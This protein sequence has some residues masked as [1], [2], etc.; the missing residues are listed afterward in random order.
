MEN[1]NN[2]IAKSTAIPKR[3]GIRAFFRIA[4]RTTL[5]VLSLGF[6]LILLIHIPPVQNQV[7][8]WFFAGLSS[9][10]RKEISCESFRFSITGSIELHNLVIHHHPRFGEEKM[11]EIKKLYLVFD[12]L[13]VGRQRIIIRELF[14]DTPQIRVVVAPDRNHNFQKDPFKKKLKQ[15]K[16]A[17]DDDSIVQAVFR[18]IRC[19]HILIKNAAFVI[20]HQPSG[21]QLDVPSVQLEGHYRAETDRIRIKAFGACIGNS[22]P[23]RL[24][25][26]ADFRLEADVFGGGVDKS[27]LTVHSSNGKVWFYSHCTLKNFRHPSLSFSGSLRSELDEIKH[28]ARVN[29]ELS[30]LADLRFSGNGFADDLTVN[31]EFRGENIQFGQFRFANFSGPVTYHNQIITV[32]EASGSAYDGSI[33]G[34]G[35]ITIQKENKS[36][37]FVATARE[38]DLAELTRDLKIP[39]ELSTAL[40]VDLKIDAD[41]FNPEDVLVTGSA[42]GIEKFSAGNSV[43]PDDE[44]TPLLLTGEFLFKNSVFEIT[45]A[46]ITHPDHEITMDNCRFAKSVLAGRIDGSTSDLQDLA[47]RIDDAVPLDYQFPALDGNCRFSIN[48]DGTP[49]AYDVFS[50]LQ[51]NEMRFRDTSL[52]AVGMS[53]RIDPD[54]LEVTDFTVSGPALQ[55][56]GIIKWRMPDPNSK[57]SMELQSAALTIDSFNLATLKSAFGWDITGNSSGSVNIG[58]GNAA[59]TLPS[60]IRLSDLKLADIPVDNAQ[61]TGIATTKGIHEAELSVN[62]GEAFIHSA[63][64]Y[65]LNGDLS[66]QMTGRDIPFQYIPG[67]YATGGTFNFEATANPSVGTR[68]IVY[69]IDGDN[70]S[71]GEHVSKEL[72]IDGTVT[73]GDLPVIEWDASLDQKT[74]VSKGKCSLLHPYPCNLEVDLS[75]FPLSVFS[76]FINRDKLQPRP[77]SGQVSMKA[78]LEGALTDRSTIVGNIWLEDLLLN[79]L[80]IE[81]RLDSPGTLEL[82][83][84]QI[85]I[86][87]L[88]FDHNSARFTISGDVRSD[89][90]MSIDANGN[91][92]LKAIERLTGFFEST[93]GNCD[94]QIRLDGSWS[95]PDF[96]GNCTFQE[97]FAYLPLFNTGLEDYHAEI[98]FSEKIGK[99]IYMEGLAGGSYLGGI[100]EFG[101]AKYMPE[102]FDIRLAGSDIEFEYPRG[103]QSS[104]DINMEINGNLPEINIAGEIDIKQSRYRSRINY[105]TMI[106]NESRAK[107]AFLEKRKTARINGEIRPFFNPQFNLLVKADDNVFI[108]NN[109]ARVELNMKLEIL[110]SLKKPR[111]LGH[112]DALHGDITFLQ[113]NYELMSASIDFADPSKVDPVII[114]QAGATIDDYRVVLDISGR[115]YS[116]LTIRPS[117]TPPLNDVDLWNLLLIGKTR[118]N[119]ASG[120][121]YLAGGVAYVTGSIQEQIER[122]FEYWMGFDEFSIDPIMSTSNESPSARFTVKKRF[123]PNLSVLYSRSASSASDLLLLEYQIADKLFV[124]GHKKE[125]NSIGLDLIYRWEFDE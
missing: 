16:R 35:E 43:D 24:D 121:D 72:K 122:R 25:S 117:S 11:V 40:D 41:G 63:F 28:L 10:I 49:R 22:H 123:G 83:N 70:F 8:Q 19:D 66:M 3:S 86:P 113:R 109:I 29:P 75:A 96:S 89:G 105:K 54:L 65:T 51:S 18:A 101:I 17:R 107:L 50:T 6:T 119:M 87:T 125:D 67:L 74:V 38:T 115:I 120:E 81:V 47:H 34:S 56:S 58:P 52:G 36:L 102:L 112:V 53:V 84:R 9:A 23:R 79:Y 45:H 99:I 59:F 118:E 73:L 100:G 110:G 39:F 5:V 2:N 124:I 48:L 94:F 27:F 7:G 57:R 30:G 62:S 85:T 88:F 71:S 12:P 14:A 44:W 13:S 68:Q 92:N 77:F 111:V 31:S 69:H 33:V 114:L 95:D 15:S 60:E 116:D 55:S 106:V 4:F 97:F 46:T 82:K 20:D 98:Q 1:N 21:Y 26:L 61:L 90:T 78:K 104:G 76:E 32:P 37:H 91:L 108:D 42:T 80:G 103:F 64:D 93:R